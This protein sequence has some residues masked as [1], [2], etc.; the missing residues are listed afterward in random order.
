MLHCEILQ[1]ISMYFASSLVALTNL[2]VC[3]WST[4]GRHGSTHKSLNLHGTDV[5]ACHK[6]L[7]AL[8]APDEQLLTNRQPGMTE[9]AK[10]ALDVVPCSSQAC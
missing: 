1:Y 10:L 9:S 7:H 5:H 3:W 4:S 2:M 6:A 8:P